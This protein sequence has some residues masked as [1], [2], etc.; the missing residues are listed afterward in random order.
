MSVL[1]TVFDTAYVIFCTAAFLY[2]TIYLFFCKS[3]STS[4]SKVN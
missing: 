4:V 1:L 3:S 2:L